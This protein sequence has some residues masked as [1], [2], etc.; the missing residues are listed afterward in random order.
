MYAVRGCRAQGSQGTGCMVMLGAMEG[1]HWTTCAH[2]REGRTGR[3]AAACQVDP[4]LG[5]LENSLEGQALWGWDEAGTE[6]GGGDRSKPH[7]S[8][9]PDF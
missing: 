1:P 3:T 8:L 7:S 2:R 4:A 6:P 9:L 5:C